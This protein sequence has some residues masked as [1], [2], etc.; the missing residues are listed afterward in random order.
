MWWVF[1]GVSCN[2]AVFCLGTPFG[3]CSGPKVPAHLLPLSIAAS[4]SCFRAA[5]FS[6]RSFVEHCFRAGPKQ[7]PY[8]GPLFGTA[9]TNLYRRPR[10]RGH[11]TAPVLDHFSALAGR[12]RVPMRPVPADLRRSPVGLAGSF[13]TLACGASTSKSYRALWRERGSSTLFQRGPRQH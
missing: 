13:A 7:G 1:G 6:G 2:A 10:N 9:L 4:P 11:Y 5:R 8:S 12:R 3:V